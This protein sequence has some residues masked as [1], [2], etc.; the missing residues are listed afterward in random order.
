MDDGRWATRLVSEI[1]SAR[2]AIVAS[3]LNLWRGGR[4]GE[5][6]LEKPPRTGNPEEEAPVPSEPPSQTDQA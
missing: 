6:E 2:A 4:P 3:Y 5:E 1:G